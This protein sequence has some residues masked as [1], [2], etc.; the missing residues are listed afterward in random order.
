MQFFVISDNSDTLTGLRLAGME[1]VLV[2]EK[3]DVQDA[4]SK[5]ISNPKVGIVLITEKLA[6]L[7]PELIY[8]L[9]LKHTMTLVVEIPDRFGTGRSP[10]SITRYIR[11]A[12]GIKV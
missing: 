4:I 1:G 7:C 6:A 10:D 12:I 8:D 5:A 2:S 11:E 3:R 9:K